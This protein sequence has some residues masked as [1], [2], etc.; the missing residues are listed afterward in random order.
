MGY[1]LLEEKEK[2]EDNTTEQVPCLLNDCLGMK[3]RR[4]EERNDG[5]G[6]CARVVPNVFGLRIR[7]IFIFL[8]LTDPSSTF[9]SLIRRRALLFSNQ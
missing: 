7:K 3:G 5:R 8:V 4:K 9:G 1:R 6:G 2:K